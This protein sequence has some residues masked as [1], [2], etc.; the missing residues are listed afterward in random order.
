MELRSGLTSG[1]AGPGRAAQRGPSTRGVGQSIGYESRL[2][3]SQHPEHS[4]VAAASVVGA[5][6]HIDTC[7]PRSLCAI[8]HKRA[9]QWSRLSRWQPADGAAAT[10]KRRPC[11]SKG[12]AALAAP[13]RHSPH[14]NH[15]LD[16]LPAGDYE[17]L[18]S[19]LELIPM[20]LG[21]VLLRTRCPLAARL[22]SHDVHRFPAVCHGGWRVGGNCRRR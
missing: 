4:L 8:P 19:H 12:R 21:E 7:S 6:A 17:R 15:L 5:V 14:Q 16:A 20:E 10:G 13:A 22:F 1:A 3:S 2:T 11:P 18:A 9:A